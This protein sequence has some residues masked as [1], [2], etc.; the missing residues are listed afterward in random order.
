MVV[1]VDVSPV[2]NLHFLD[3][4]AGNVFAFDLLISEH[5]HSEFT[6]LYTSF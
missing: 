2:T 5:D 1:W 6:D 3:G 4:V